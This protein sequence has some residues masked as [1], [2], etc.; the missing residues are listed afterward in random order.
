MASFRGL[1]LHEGGGRVTPGIESVDETRLPEGDVT[2]A[3]E[4]STLNYKDGMIVQGL[5]RLVRQYPHVPGIDFAGTVERS[6]SPDFQP[7]DPVVLPGWRVGEM[8]WGGLAEKARVPAS[9]L[10]KRPTGL[11]AL[12]TMAIGT[13]GFT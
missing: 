12:Q 6:D 8:Q 9:Y 3:V 10:V 2:V 5:G 11:S 1:V 13:A 4:Y 7:G